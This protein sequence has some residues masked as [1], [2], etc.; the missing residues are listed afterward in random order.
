MGRQPWLVNGLMRTEE[1]VS[2]LVSSG[3]AWFTLL[4][5]AGMY[6]L[7]SILFLFLVGREVEQGPDPA[8]IA[9]LEPM[10]AR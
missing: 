8:P 1:G 10:G 7:L 3:A 4:G 2:P 6:T 5:F 9:A